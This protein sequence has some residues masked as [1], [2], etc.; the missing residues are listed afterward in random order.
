MNA[1]KQKIYISG[2]ITG[3]PEEKVRYDFHEA[4]N[5]LRRLFP[6]YELVNPLHNVLPFDAPWE[7]HIEADLRI[8]E[9]CNAVYFMDG[10]ENSLG[11]QV[12]H[13]RAVELLIDRYYQSPI[14]QKSHEKTIQ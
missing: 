7:E 13:A 5:R 11:C 9:E 2:P 14:K 8:M 10:W 12:E 1:L 4:E 3:L 6:T